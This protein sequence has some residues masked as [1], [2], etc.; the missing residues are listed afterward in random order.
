MIGLVAGEEGEGGEGE[1]HSKVG[2]V[3]PT[4]TIAAPAQ[5]LLRIVFWTY[6]SF[7]GFQIQ[8]KWFTGC[9]LCRAVI[10]NDCFLGN[11]KK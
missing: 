5:K 8:K 6:M 9:S 4:I 3:G 11:G 2:P 7:P 1:S 10:L